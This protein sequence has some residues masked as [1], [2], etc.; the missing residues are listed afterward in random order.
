MRLLA[1]VL[2]IGNPIFLH[3]AFSYMTDVY[4]YALA[5]GGALVWITARAGSPADGPIVGRR[6]ALLAATL[7]GGSFWIRQFC[8]AVFPALVAAGLLQ[9]VVAGDRQALRR[10][11]AV[12]VAATVWFTVVVLS[13]FVWANVTGLLE[14]ISDRSSG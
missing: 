13:Y 1:A 11:M 3:V 12:V 8:A 10:S 2:L 4:G 9:F 7:A 14:G 5:L 6:D